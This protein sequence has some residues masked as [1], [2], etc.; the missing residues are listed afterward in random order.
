MKK[1]CLCIIPARANS[2]G[3]KNKNFKLLNGKPLIQY[4]ID[5]AKKIETHCDIVV[6]SDHKKVKKICKK[7]KLEFFGFRPN[8]D[9]WKVMALSSFTSPNNKY[10]NPGRGSC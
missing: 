9:E 2:K 1:N 4:T 7:N 6:S 8:S 5:V 3:V 10:Y